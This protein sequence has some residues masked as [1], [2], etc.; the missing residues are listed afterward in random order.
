[1]LYRLWLTLLPVVWRVFL[2]PAAIEWSPPADCGTAGC[3]AQDIGL[4]L[5]LLA[6][7][8]AIAYWEGAGLG[9]LGL[10]S[11]T[12]IRGVILGLVFALPIGLLLPGSQSAQFAPGV[13]LRHAVAGFLEEC[14]YR[15]FVQRRLAADFGQILAA[16]GAA[17][18]FA[19]GH[20][21]ALVVAYGAGSSAAVTGLTYFFL[22]GCVLG[23]LF[24][25]TASAWAPA[26]P[27]AA[28]NVARTLSPLPLG[29]G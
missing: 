15:G 27:H 25:A 17:A 28:F 11:E 9:G 22:A 21:P 14:A 2:L 26:L 5:L 23:A 6:P 10:A 7:F 8:V 12:T 29:G 16:V 18:L 1:M 3:V 20:G 4:N 13:A 24:A 19:L